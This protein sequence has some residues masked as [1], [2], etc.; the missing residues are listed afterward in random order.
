MFLETIR[1]K[2]L[3]TSVTETL[4]FPLS[5]GQALP[6]PPDFVFSPSPPRKFLC[7]KNIT[8]ITNWAQTPMVRGFVVV[9]FYGDVVMF[10]PENGL[11]YGKKVKDFDDFRFVLRQGRAG[12]P[13]LFPRW[14]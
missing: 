5:G 6:A 13:E 9:M 10:F 1:Q 12:R 11:K 3:S 14:E 2:T 8:N 7:E 4:L